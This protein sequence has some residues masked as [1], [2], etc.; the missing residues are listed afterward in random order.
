[1]CSQLM[2]PLW[3]HMFSLLYLLVQP[4]D[5]GSHSN[6][7][8]LVCAVAAG[9]LLND[10]DA[11]TLLLTFVCVFQL[12]ERF[13]CPLPSM[14]VASS[15]RMALPPLPPRC[16]RTCPLSWLGLQ[17]PSRCVWCGVRVVHFVLVVLISAFVHDDVTHAIPTV[18]NYVCASKAQHMCF[19]ASSIPVQLRPSCCYLLIV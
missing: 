7:F 3:S 13:R 2:K 15:T 6:A 19:C 18:A 9:G 17:S 14:T 1:M 10:F 12:E 11:L 16:R 4:A 8:S 5:F